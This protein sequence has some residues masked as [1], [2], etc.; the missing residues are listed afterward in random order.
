MKYKDNSGVVHDITLNGSSLQYVTGSEIHT[1]S[2]SDVI[3]GDGYPRR[4]LT[5]NGK[6][7]GPPI[8]VIHG[9]Q[10]SAALGS[11]Y[12]TA[13]AISSNGKIIE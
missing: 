10:V 13:A 5:V 4:I 8:E 2:P 7:P 6:Y 3:T 11:G 12:C 1:V 9:S